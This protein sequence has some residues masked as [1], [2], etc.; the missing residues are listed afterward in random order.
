VNAPPTRESRPG[1]NRAASISTAKIK[2]AAV[3]VE[4][5]ADNL[6]QLQRRLVLEAVETAEAWWWLR[7][8]EEYEAARPRPEEFHGRA[9]RADLSRR[10][11]DLTELAQACRARAAMARR[12]VDEDEWAELYEQVVAC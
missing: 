11:C 9:S 1:R 7:R 8:A 3:S 10:W 2:A 4:Q 6:T 12:G 5:T